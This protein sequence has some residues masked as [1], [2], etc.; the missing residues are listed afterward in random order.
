M[1]GRGVKAQWGSGGGGTAGKGWRREE[2]SKVVRVTAG[3][4]WKPQ[5]RPDPQQ[6]ERAQPEVEGKVSREKVPLARKVQ[7]GDYLLL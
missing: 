1:A 5:A 3:R 7:R 4:V 6:V 2:K